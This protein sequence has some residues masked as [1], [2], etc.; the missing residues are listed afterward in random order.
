MNTVFL[1]PRGLRDDVPGLWSFA[2]DDFN[3]LL[4]GSQCRGRAKQHADTCTIVDQV[5]AQLNSR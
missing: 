5:R 2:D 3:I 1:F 4:E